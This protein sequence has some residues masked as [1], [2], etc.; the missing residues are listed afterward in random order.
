M[1]EV[2]VAAASD[3]LIALLVFELE[4]GSARRTTACLT[5]SRS[6]KKEQT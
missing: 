2:F 4:P 1:L 5:E 6:D 3:G